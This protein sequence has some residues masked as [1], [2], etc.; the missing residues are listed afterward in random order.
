LDTI[1]QLVDRRN[2]EHLPLEIIVVTTDHDIPALEAELDKV[3]VEADPVGGVLLAGTKLHGSAVYRLGGVLS[4]QGQAQNRNPAG[5]VGA[6]DSELGNWMV[7]K[8]GITD[9]T[10]L[11]AWW[12]L[13]NGV[14][15]VVPELDKLARKSGDVGTQATLLKDRFVAYVQHKVDAFG[16]KPIGSLERYEQ[17]EHLYEL[18]SALRMREFSKAKREIKAGLQEASRSDALKE[19]VMAMMAYRK[20]KS[21]AASRKAMEIKQADEGFSQLSRQLPHTTYGKLASNWLRAQ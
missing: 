6:S 13:V 19:E 14:Y 20:L 3:G 9:P 17:G 18:L 15:A 12:H 5:L 4:P 7:S 16:D 21:M 10:V 2:T 1:R 8:D 11:R